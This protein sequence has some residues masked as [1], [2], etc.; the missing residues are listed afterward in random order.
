MVPVCINSL[1]SSMFCLKLHD[2][3][4]KMPQ[5]SANNR[6]SDAETAHKVQSVLAFAQA[7]DV[8]PTLM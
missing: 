5:W 2:Q 7:P 3:E 8:Q 1:N 6:S 4:D